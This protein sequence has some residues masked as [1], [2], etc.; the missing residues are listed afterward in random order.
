M[1]KAA[2]IFLPGILSTGEARACFTVS[3]ETSLIHSALP[4]DPD[5]RLLIARVDIDWADQRLVHKGGVS[6]RVRSVIQGSF[7]GELMILWSPSSDCSRPFENGRSGL[8]VGLPLGMRGGALIVEAFE[9]S[10][11]SGYRMP[12]HY[13]VPEDYLEAVRERRALWVAE[14]Q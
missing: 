12:D 3:G 2:A 8:F 1:L 10:R 9:I 5:P 7:D 13:R 6:A 14:A 4:I 11:G